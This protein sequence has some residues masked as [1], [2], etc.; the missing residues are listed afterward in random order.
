[1]VLNAADRI[2]VT[3]TTTKNEFSTITT[4]PIEVI[5]N[6]YDVTPLNTGKLDAKFTISH[7][8]SLLTG[9]NP[10]NLWQVLSELISE[11]LDFKNA[12]QLQFAGVV[13]HD[14]LETMISLHLEPFLKLEGY[15]SHKEALK[16]QKK[17]QVLLL[18]EIDSEETRGIIPGKLFEYMASKRP[19]LG[20][21][22]KGWEVSDIVTE[23]QTGST[24]D[25]SEHS[26]IKKLL[27]EWFADYQKGKL[28]IT[29]VGIE[30][31]S[32][33]ELTKQMVSIIPW[34]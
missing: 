21:G 26:Q 31:Y 3:S 34:E 29:S 11:N 16:F 9:R 33:K 24:V 15:L 13:S 28:T 17:S 10:K 25:Y 8:G 7:I 19:I 2:T 6:G 23:T 30:K 1:M 18:A 27:L 20:I 5:T 32:R 12:V 4:K 22:P 14:V